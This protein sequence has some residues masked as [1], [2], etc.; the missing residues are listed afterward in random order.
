LDRG[1]ISLG[2]FPEACIDLALHSRKAHREVYWYRW[3]RLTGGTP[4]DPGR[5]TGVAAVNLTQ[6]YQ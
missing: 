2:K 6:Q 4:V 1:G 3:G 5:S